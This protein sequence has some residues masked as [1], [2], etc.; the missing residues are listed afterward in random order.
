VLKVFNLLIAK[1]LSCSTS[2]STSQRSD[3]EVDWFICRGGW[4]VDY[5]LDFGSNEALLRYAKATARPN[6]S[7]DTY[8]ASQRI[9]ALTFLLHLN[10][11]AALSSDLTERGRTDA[12]LVARNFE[13]QE[14]SILF[15]NHLLNNYRALLLYASYFMGTQDSLEIENAIR[16]IG[17]I[18]GKHEDV[19]FETPGEPVVCEGSVS[20]EI[21]GLMLLT[22]IAV[23]SYRTP[24]ANIWQKWVISRSKATLMKY[25][26]ENRW[27]VPQIGDLTPNWT[28][29]GMLDFMDGLAFPDS[30]STYRAVWQKDLARLGI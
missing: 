20:Y 3:I 14:K 30:S 23:C 22:D 19:L 21:H 13:F 29:R 5:I 12:R 15:N 9:A 2:R 28:P 4:L 10:G 11:R 8:S 26:Y 24:L 25:R 16:K 17:D 27:I 18:L 6:L 1:F 7:E